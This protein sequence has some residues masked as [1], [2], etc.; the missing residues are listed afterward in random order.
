[1]KKDKLQKTYGHYQKKSN[2][3]VIILSICLAVVM[4][5]MCLLI[6]AHCNWSVE[7]NTE[8][9]K[10][11]MHYKEPLKYPTAHLVGRYVCIKPVSM[12]VR[13]AHNVNTNQMANTK[14]NIL[15]KNGDTEPF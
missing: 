5:L 6:F 10:E 7:F 15:H 1:M 3:A 2:A 14:L 4:M 9:T 8:N 12:H 13:P 11:V